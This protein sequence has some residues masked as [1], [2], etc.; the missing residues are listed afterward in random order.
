M[1]LKEHPKIQ[2]P[3]EVIAVDRNVAKGRRG[4]FE[5]CRPYRINEASSKQRS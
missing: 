4:N 2:W 5:R 1:R 3:P